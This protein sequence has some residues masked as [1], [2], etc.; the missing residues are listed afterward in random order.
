[1]SEKRYFKR[2]NFPAEVQVTCDEN[3]L[4]GDLLDISLKGALINIHEPGILQVGRQAAIR[5]YL[6]S[7]AI[8]ITA[9]ADVVHQQGEDF[10][11]KF[12]KID[13]ESIGHLRR[14]LELNLGSSE[15]IASE[16]EFILKKAGEKE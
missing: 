4:H 8:T 12:F 15:T 5:I 7:A 9:E 14:L 2:V 1:M 10:G 13:A 16:L 6:S 3:I 11:F